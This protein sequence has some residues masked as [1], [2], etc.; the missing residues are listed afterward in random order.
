MWGRA[1][2]NALILAGIVAAGIN[3]KQPL[4]TE[5]IAKWAIELMTWASDRWVARVEECSSRSSVEQA[6]KLIERLIRFSEHYKGRAHGRP[7]EM[8]AIERGC[9]PRSLLTR[10]SRHLRGK[11]LEDALDQ[12]VASDII[13][14]G[15]IDGKEVYWIKL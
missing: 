1:N 7:V 5:S 4:I 8:K 6:S 3:P 2:Q 14:T 12:L 13:A 10:M 9:M 15:E 11:D